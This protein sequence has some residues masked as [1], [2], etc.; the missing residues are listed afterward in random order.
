MDD[1]GDQVAYLVLVNGTPV[2]SSDRHE[3]GTV[4]EVLAV[5]NDDIFDGIMVGDTHGKHY[6]AAEHVDAIYERGV[7]LNIDKASCTSS[8]QLPPGR[9]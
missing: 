6:V 2:Y 4:T 9:R 8:R 1:L 3:V 7:V 5:G